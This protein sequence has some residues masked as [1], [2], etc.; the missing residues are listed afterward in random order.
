[1]CCAF[2]VLTE[3]SK[4]DLAV[5]RTFQ[6]LA[7]GVIPR[8]AQFSDAHQRHLHLCDQCLSAITGHKA[9]SVQDLPDLDFGYEMGKTHSASG[10]T[11]LDKTPSL[12]RGLRDFV[13]LGRGEKRD[14]HVEDIESVVSCSAGSKASSEASFADISSLESDRQ[15]NSGHGRESSTSTKMYR[16]TRKTTATKSDSSSESEDGSLTDRIK[17]TKPT[18]LPYK[19]VTKP[20]PQGYRDGTAVRFNVKQPEVTTVG[21]AAVGGMERALTKDSLCSGHTLG[22]SVTIPLVEEGT[23]CDSYLFCYKLLLEYCRASLFNDE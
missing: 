3:A 9:S 13:N 2:Q 22:S 18:D 1:M 10:Y 21:S 6:A 4:H 8:P 11:S 14:R 16:K 23:V 12:V 15:E 7:A 20:P 17:G 19:E 5:L